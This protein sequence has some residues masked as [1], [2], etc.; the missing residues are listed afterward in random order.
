[1]SSSRSVAA[2]AA[3][4]TV[5]VAAVVLGAVTPA[6]A[7]SVPVDRA[8]SLR[9]AGLG[10]SREGPAYTAATAGDFDGDGLDDVIIGVPRADPQG[11][12]D[13]GSVFVVLSRRGGTATVDLRRPSDRV[14]RIL[15]RPPAVPVEDEG[16]LVGEA[17]GD[18][19]T[20]LGDVNGD[21]LDDVA[22]GAPD[23]TPD[24]NRALAGA[25][26]VVFGRRAGGTLD[27]AA[28]GDGGFR[29]DGPRRAG[30]FGEKLAGLPGTA[31]AL[32]VADEGVVHLL[33]AA[34]A[35]GSVTGVEG[36][37]VVTGYDQGD[38]NPFYASYALRP[39]DFAGDVNGDGLG[40]L[41]I[42]QG[43]T[44]V[45]GVEPDESPYDSSAFVVVGGAPAALPMLRERGLRIDGVS[46]QVAAVGDVAGD[47]RPDLAVVN[48]VP[49]SP[50]GEAFPALVTGRASGRLDAAKT[51]P[52]VLRVPAPPGFDAAPLGDLDGDRRPELAVARGN[53]VGGLVDGLRIVASRRLGRHRAPPLATVRAARMRLVSLDV[54]GDTD[55]DRR[56]D[57][58]VGTGRRVLVLSAARL[59]RR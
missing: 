27:L 7:A 33:P 10:L 49:R 55:G 12:R 41:L 24:E 50:F 45:E 16:G 11:R 26:Y 56:G 9:I 31:P 52:G 37:P 25:V 51:A 35:A 13:A 47:G 46:G 34:R 30:R 42:G 20:A 19:V 22:I 23:A 29:V 2:S 28:L 48:A 21:G 3:A 53:E 44:D 5:A 1:M 6:L 38:F 58:L 43:Q 15:G 54:A 40:D 14:L 18:A 59:R 32:A 8:T 39:L 36:A 57:L 4:A 17:A